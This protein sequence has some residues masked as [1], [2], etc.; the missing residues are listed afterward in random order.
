MKCGLGGD[1]FK[2]LEGLVSGARAAAKS[3]DDEPDGPMDRKFKDLCDGASCGV[4]CQ[5]H[6]PRQPPGEEEGLALAS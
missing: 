3:P 6:R 2:D 4:V 1:G 5:E